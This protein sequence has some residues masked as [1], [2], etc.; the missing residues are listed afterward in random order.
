[1]A[2][3]IDKRYRTF[4]GNCDYADVNYGMYALP[5]ALP[6]TAETIATEVEAKTRA[7][8]WSLLRLRISIDWK[9][10]PF[11]RYETRVE[12]WAVPPGGMRLNR[13]ELSVL[14]LIGVIVVCLTLIFLGIIIWKVWES[15]REKKISQFVCPLCQEVFETASAFDSHMCKIHGICKYT[16]PYCGAS[17]DTSEQLA[18]HITDMHK[19]EKLADTL[20]WVAYG[21]LAFGGVLVITKLI[22]TKTIMVSEKKHAK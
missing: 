14:S 11:P 18:Q 12:V 5:W 9:W 4:V 15:G 6:Q 17:F 1:M 3:Y 20:K 19:Q 2:V 7:D 21:L 8:G 13:K 10:L 22:P 16:C